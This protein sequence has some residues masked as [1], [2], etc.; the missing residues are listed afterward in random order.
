VDIEDYLTHRQRVGVS[1]SILKREIGVLKAAVNWANKKKRLDLPNPVAR[2]DLVEPPGRMRWLDQDQSRALMNAAAEARQAP[3]LVDFIRLA[4]H[5]GMRKGEMLGLEWSRVDLQ[6]GYVL[7]GA[8][9]QKN[10]ELGSVPLNRTAH[11]VILSHARFR[12]TYCPA[13][14]WVFCDKHGQGI[15]SIK[16]GFAAAVRR[17][18]IAHCTPH[19]LRRTCGSWLVQARTPIQEVARLLR[20]SDIQVTMSVYAHL[21]PNQLQQTVQV[22]D[23][24]NLVIAQETR[25]MKTNVNS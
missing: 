14:R 24:H 20:H 22:L 16:K 25:A 7:L 15:N 21:M 13:S 18:G 3:H 23:R 8:G 17:A 6:Q 12:A 11:E 5:T 2:L 19:D 4:L 9:D 10:G 1:E